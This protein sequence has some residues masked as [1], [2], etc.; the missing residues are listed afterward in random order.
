MSKTNAFETEILALILTA[1]PIPNLAINDNVAPATAITVA[2][3]TANPGETGNM[4]TNEAAYTGYARQT[5]ARTSGG[6]SVANGVASPVN[7]IVFPAPTGG[8]ETITYFSLGTGVSNNM[9]YYGTVTP[10][11]SITPGGNAPEL[12][13][14]STISE[15]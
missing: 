11:I 3:H 4:S 2:L 13:T 1:S 12:T 9:F 10:N 6:W 15:D 14:A 5:V 8:T 7:P